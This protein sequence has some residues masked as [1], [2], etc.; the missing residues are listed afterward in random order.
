[1]AA[2]STIGVNVYTAWQTSA[3]VRPT[4]GYSLLS[5]EIV[6]IPEFD[7]SPEGIDVTP[8]AELVAMRYI[9]GLKDNG[10]DFGMSGNIN[11]TDMTTWEGLV[12]TAATNIPLG[13]FLEI[14]I[15]IPG[16]TKAYFLS[17]T[18][19]KLGLPGITVNSAFQG[20]YHIVP[21]Q[22]H[23]WDTKGSITSA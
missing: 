12:T 17:G 13:K 1:M 23:G 2:H 19:I 3:G 21:Y 6:E 5:Q 10:Q 11:D 18:P 14:M 9:A 8:L 15:V 22:D 7:S 20:T 4:T 16:V